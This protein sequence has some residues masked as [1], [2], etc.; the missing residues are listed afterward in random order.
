MANSLTAMSPTYWSKIM[1]RKRYKT[2]VFQALASFEEKASL[3]NGQKVDRPYRSNIVAETYS[4]GTALTAQDLTATSDQLTVNQFK[5]MLLYVDQVDKIQNKYSAAQHWA[6]EAQVRLSNLVD[7]HFLYEVVNANNVIDDATLGGT[8]GNGITVTTAN[9]LNIFGKI[10]RKLTVQNVPADQRYFVISPE[11]NDVLWQYIAG[12]ESLLGDKTGETGNIGTFAGLKLYLSN[13]LPGSAVLTLA[14]ATPSNGDT[15][16]I[17]GVVFTFVSSIGTTAGNVLIGASSTESAANLVTL[18]TTP[19]TTTATGVALSAADQRTVSNWVAS[20]STDQFTVF[21]KGASY[22]VVS[23]T[24]THASNIWTLAKQ[25]QNLM[26]GRKGAV[27]L[28]I[29]KEPTV[30]MASTV[31]AGKAGMNILP[32][33][34][35][36]TYTFYQ[37]KNELVWVKT[38]SDS[39]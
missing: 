34:V 38:R 16:T 7:A 21:A 17:N 28:V 23:E 8:A 5:A 19:G 35:F 37:G 36:G 20:S 27:D 9:I 2:E 25:I 4:K 15:V 30:E 29:Q 31:S 26:A 1:G 13:N 33:T 12:K 6:E 39:F 3:V 10:N 24:L 11:F 32:M 18:I 14:G 22:M